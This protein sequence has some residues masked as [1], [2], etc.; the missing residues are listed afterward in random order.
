MSI[1]RRVT[2]TR[3][4]DKLSLVRMAFN[5]FTI[6]IDLAQDMSTFVVGDFVAENTEGKGL[7]VY[8]SR[9]IPGATPGICA[10]LAKIIRIPSI[11]RCR[12]Y[13][14]TGR[15]RACLFS[16][17]KSAE[18]QLS[19]LNLTKIRVGSGSPHWKGATV[20]TSVPQSEIRVYL[21]GFGRTPRQVIFTFAP[22]L[23]V[24]VDVKMFYVILCFLFLSRFYF[25][26]FLN[27][28][29]VLQ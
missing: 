15:R 24:N 12:Y 25:L 19:T 5:G 29:N 22:C 14:T 6:S 26:T 16:L 8:E 28:L 20:P 10:S 4:C 11:I 27:F 13:K 17:P 2:V 7:G 23:V 1:V 3:V 18:T 9:L 21:W